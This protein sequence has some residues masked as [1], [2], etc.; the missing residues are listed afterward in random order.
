MSA[1]TFSVRRCLANR[2]LTVRTA[3]FQNGAR[4]RLRGGARPFGE[5]HGFRAAVSGLAEPDSRPRCRQ[6][7]PERVNGSYVS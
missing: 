7:H 5:A 4:R 3:L 1:D 6:K 2:P